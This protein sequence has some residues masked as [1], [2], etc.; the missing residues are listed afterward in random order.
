M[1]VLD[2]FSGIG[3]FSR[4]LEQAGMKTVAFC[5]IEPFCQ[6][7]L[8]KHW[9]DVPIYSDIRGLNAER[10]RNDGIPPID[11]ICGGFPC[12]PY[13]VAGKRKGAADDRHLW[14]EMRRLIEEIRPAWVIGE[15][16]AN[17]VELALDTVLFDL[18]A[19]GYAWRAFVIPACAVDAPHPRKR[20]WIIAHSQG[21]KGTSAH[22]STAGKAGQGQPRRMGIGALSGPEWLSQ[23]RICGVDDGLSAQVDRLTALGNAVVPQIPEVI[24][25]NILLCV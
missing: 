16:V 23:S 25:K 20:V 22:V 11:L 14:P 21:A 2:L 9:P 3:G 15:N 12:Q 8:Q 19:L 13:S 17:F 18:E 6:K 4:G 7:V 5:E 1:N 10:L 24:G